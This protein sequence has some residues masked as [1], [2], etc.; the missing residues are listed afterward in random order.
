MAFPEHMGGSVSARVP[1]SSA[2]VRRVFMHHI[3]EVEVDG[4]M[5]E[6]GDQREDEE[7]E[8]LEMSK[9]SEATLTVRMK[10]KDDWDERRLK[11]DPKCA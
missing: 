6:Q 4:P 7:V 8:V 1:R 9:R 2:E 10:H 3:V 11:L 5:E